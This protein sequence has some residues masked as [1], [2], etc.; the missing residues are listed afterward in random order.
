[1][2]LTKV[3]PH[4]DGA[5]TNAA[6]ATIITV[7]AAAKAIFT[8]KTARLRIFLYFCDHIIVFTYDY[9]SNHIQSHWRHATRE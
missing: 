1:M 9:T 3:N 6:D 7:L 4:P 5:Y 2:M 8:E